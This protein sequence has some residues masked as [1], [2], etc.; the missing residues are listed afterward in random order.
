M[1]GPPNPAL[2]LPLVVTRPC[3]VA[4]VPW[5]VFARYRLIRRLFLAGLRLGARERRN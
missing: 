3:K 1:N 4:A 5:C 2:L